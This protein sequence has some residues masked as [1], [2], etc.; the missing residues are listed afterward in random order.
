MPSI[1][2]VIHLN[3]LKFKPFHAT[4]SE[5]PYSIVTISIEDM[6]F[7]VILLAKGM[8]LFNSNYYQMP[9]FNPYC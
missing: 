1:R 2:V 4:I 9:D 6:S 3:H 5:G 7:T 8:L